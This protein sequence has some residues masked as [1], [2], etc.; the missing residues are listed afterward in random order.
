M[1]QQKHYLNIPSKCS[2]HTIFS[3]LH[4]ASRVD[5]VWDEYLPESLEAEIHSKNL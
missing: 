2:Y 4:H 3:Q 5:V 1:E